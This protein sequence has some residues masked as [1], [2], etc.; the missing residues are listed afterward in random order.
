MVLAKF[1]H[2]NFNLIRLLDVCIECY[3]LCLKI[4]PQLDEGSM[5]V[6]LRQHGEMINRDDREITVTSEY[7]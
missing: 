7:M 3:V 2:P 5:F 4:L 6:D 1:G